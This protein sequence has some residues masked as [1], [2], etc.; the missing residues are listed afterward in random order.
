M[1]RFR[2]LICALF[3][4]LFS[5]VLSTA[6]QAQ[7]P[8]TYVSAQRGN[9]ANACDS[10]SPCRTFAR[11]LIQ[12]VAGGE[13]VVLDPGDYGQVTISQAVMIVAEP[14]SYGGITVGKGGVGILIKAGPSD[15]IVLRGLTLNGLSGGAGIGFSTGSA[16]H[17]ENCAINGFDR[18]IQSAADGRLFVKDT[19]VRNS[20]VTGISITSAFGA[21]TALIDH[22]R[23]EKNSSGVFANNAKFTIRDSIAAG[24]SR[25]GFEAGNGAEMSLENCLATTNGTG[26]G[27]GSAST[28][29]V[30]NST[31]TQNGVGIAAP[32]FRSSIISFGNNRLAGNT[33][34][35]SFSGVTALQ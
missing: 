8:Q 3:V 20:R 2:H 31:I 19:V 29:L 30:S 33:V 16:L 22:C 24:N 12:V 32:S 13:I 9:D 1:K 10:M 28:A 18:G 23:L 21:A 26:I 35:G 11:A 5:I 14:G 27:L 25:I 6:A 34:D 17:I 4:V 7:L 15:V